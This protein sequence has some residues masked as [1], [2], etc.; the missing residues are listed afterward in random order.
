MN[1]L[2]SSCMSYLIKNIGDLET[3]LICVFQGDKQEVGR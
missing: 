1:V 3:L 2:I